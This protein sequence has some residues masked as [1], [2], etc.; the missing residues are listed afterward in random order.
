MGG[1]IAGLTRDPQRSGETLRHEDPGPLAFMIVMPAQGRHED[2][3]YG[4]AYRIG[5]KTLTV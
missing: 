4:T 5:M 2:R 3:G 1:L